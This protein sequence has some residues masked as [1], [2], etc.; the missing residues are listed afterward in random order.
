MGSPDIL[1]RPTPQLDIV[2][3]KGLGAGFS[4]SVK[5]QNLL[6]PARVT[7]QGDETIDAVKRGWRVGL[8]LGWSAE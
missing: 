1:E 4:S 8:S 3:R 5:L 6:G 7:T 2:A